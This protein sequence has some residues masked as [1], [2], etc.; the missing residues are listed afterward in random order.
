MVDDVGSH[1][2]RQPVGNDD[3][4]ELERKEPYRHF[5]HVDVHDAGHDATRD[6]ADGRYVCVD[7]EE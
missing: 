3:D 1:G 4:G 7:F 5:R 6:G 2:K